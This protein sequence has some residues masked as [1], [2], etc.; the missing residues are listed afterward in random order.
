MI[1]DMLPLKNELSFSMYEE[2]KTLNAF[3]MKYEKIHA[4]P[5]NCILYKNDLKEASSCL[6]CEAL[7]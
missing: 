3:K 5:N 4:G 7:R 6:T 1:G 2:K